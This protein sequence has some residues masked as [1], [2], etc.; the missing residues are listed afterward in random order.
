MVALHG[1]A[2]AGGEGWSADFDASKKLAVDSKKDLLVD[3]TGSDWCSWC[4]KL[5][6]EVF[7]HESFKAG[8]KD[9]FVL[10]ELDYPQDKAKLS[11]ATQKQNQELGEKYRVQGYPTILLCDAQGRPYATTGY[12]PGGPEKYVAHLNELRGIKAKRDDAMAT[13]DKAKGVDKAKAL[14]AA[15]KTMT[16]D[17]QQITQFYGDIVTSI[18]QLDKDDATGYAKAKTEAAA[19]KSAAEASNAAA[20]Q[21]FLEKIKPLLEAKDYDKALGEVKSYIKDHAD[22]QIDDKIGMLMTVGLAGPMEKNDGPACMAVV[23]EVAKAYPESDFAKG[24]DKVKGNIKA[25]LESK[26]AEKAAEKAEAKPAEK[27]EEKPTEKTE[28][29]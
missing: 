14:I 6:N 10:V 15:L 1:A 4:I 26:A 27:T 18:G 17:E 11:E 16:L 19:K 2:F 22:T 12:Q 24:A 21:F 8:V 29:K 9:S 13:A 20:Q 7:K 5:N 3:F 28:E 25:H 23:D